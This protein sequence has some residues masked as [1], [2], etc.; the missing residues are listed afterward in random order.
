MAKQQKNTQNKNKT[1]WFSA[2]TALQL[3]DPLIVLP[4][5]SP[6]YIQLKGNVPVIWT[7]LDFDAA[8]FICLSASEYRRH[9]THVGESETKYERVFIAVSILN[10]LATSNTYL[11]RVLYAK[12]T[13][14]IGFE[15]ACRSNCMHINGSFVCVRQSNVAARVICLIYNFAHTQNLV[16]ALSRSQSVLFSTSFVSMTLH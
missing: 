1:F 9:Y 13:H 2:L 10:Q 6:G 7:D 16:V 3:I 14:T 11:H 4:M 5:S 8:S 12:H 15:S